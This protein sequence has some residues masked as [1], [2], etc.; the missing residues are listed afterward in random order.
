MILQNS[1]TKG[2]FFKFQ[3]FSRTKQIPGVFQVCANPG[4]EKNNVSSLKIDPQSTN[5]D[6]KN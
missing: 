3:E 5:N 1:R 6:L 4:L 2:T